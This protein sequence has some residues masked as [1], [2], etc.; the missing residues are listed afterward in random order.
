MCL[1]SVV[2]AAVPE[3]TA[4]VVRAIYPKGNLFM[5]IRDELGTLFEDGDFED[6]FSDRG[7][8]ALSPW[9]LALVTVLQ[10]MENLSDRQAADAVRDRLSWKYLLGLQISDQ[11]F[12]FSVLSEFR[13][14]L[15]TGNAEHRLL[16]VMVKT[17]KQK[18]LLKARGRMRTDATH[19]LAAMRVMRRLECVGETLR[20]ALNAL[21]AVEPTWLKAQIE[22]DW[23]ERYS[24]RIEDTRFPTS[25]EGRLALAETYGRDGFHLLESV[26][27]EHS[28]AWLRLV[29]MVET[30]RQVW[31]QHFVFIDEKLCWRDAKATPPSLQRVDS[32]Y[33]TDARFG[34]KRAVTWIG[35][36]VHLTESCEE[37]L[38][39]L[40]VNVETT[41]AP[42]P[43]HLATLQIHTSLAEKDLLPS[44][45][46]VDS[47]YVTAEHLADCEAQFGVDLMGPV[48]PNSNWQSRANTGF[49][50]RQFEVD[51]E[52]EQVTCPLGKVSYKW[53]TSLDPRGKP[54]VR[55]HFSKRDCRPCPKRE[56]C[57]KSTT[58]GRCIT[59]RP[60]LQQKAMERARQRE[61]TDSFRH[62][63]A[64]RAG[65]EGTI[66]QSV[67]RFD[68]R[69][70][71]YRGAAKSSLQH[72][73]TAAAL[74]LLR[75]DDWFCSVEPEKT[76]VS[77]FAR[78]A[79]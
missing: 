77:Q 66:S 29:P 11:G 28:P 64:Q 50:G 12:D 22:P 42:P 40:V 7:Q 39:H 26:Y 58:K 36:R 60:L 19:V 67:R 45:H 69:H 31:V 1:K 79:A 73:A 9:R 23:F 68:I 43:D 78:L 16:N 74:N 5:R 37:D 8:P 70:C 2:I 18:G 10:F 46:L 48:H 56:L 33:E 13:S 65:I 59:L 15:V 17:L 27:D 24:H 61:S 20:A 3:E 72:H 14:R 76:R 54:V 47:G 35:Y 41:P 44:E 71:R 34:N 4:R 51:W 21:A 55:A 53:N 62:I 63:Y 75:L 57:T 49:D 38:P 25:Q 32:P 52:H 30:L 6:L